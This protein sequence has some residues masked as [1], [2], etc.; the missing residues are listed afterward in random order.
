MIQRLCI[1][2]LEHKGVTSNDTT[3]GR[4][5]M[6]IL[7]SS[8]SVWFTLWENFEEIEMTQKALLRSNG[9]IEVALYNIFME[10]SSRQQ[11]NVSIV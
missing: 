5:I 11:Q 3:K 2:M 9:R 1:L 8:M 10:R 4:N 7:Q 6:K